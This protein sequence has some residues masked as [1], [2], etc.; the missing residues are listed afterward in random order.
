MSDH[1]SYSKNLVVVRQANDKSR[2]I[3]HVLRLEGD[4]TSTPVAYLSARNP[5]WI[6]QEIVHRLIA[7]VHDLVHRPSDL[8][9]T[10]PTVESI[11]RYWGM[12]KD[13]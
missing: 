11:L 6:E 9:V 8:V 4:A 1:A 12:A 3:R 7:Q 10:G 2:L 5:D 13:E